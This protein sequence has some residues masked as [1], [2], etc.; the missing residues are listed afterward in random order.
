[1][2]RAST[3][4]GFDAVHM[5]KQQDPIV[6]YGQPLSAHLH[7]GTGRTDFSSTTNSNLPINPAHI[8]D[9]GYQPLG[10]NCPFY[11]EWALYIWPAPKLNGVTT[12]SDATTVTQQAPTGTHVDPAPYG[13]LSIVGNANAG[14][15]QANIRFTCGDGTAAQWS[16]LDGPGSPSPVDCTGVPGGVVTAEAKNPDCYDG[17]GAVRN[18]TTG[19]ITFD[20]PAGISLSHFSYSVNGQCAAGSTL[21]AQIVTQQTFIDNRTTI[22]GVANPDYNKQLRNPLNPDGSVALSFASGAYQTY[23]TDL[24]VSTGNSWRISIVNQC[25]NTTIVNACPT[26]TY[27]GTHVAS[28]QLA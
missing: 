25:L 23:H 19:V 22:N 4:C 12:L 21:I 5:R 20:A 9:P 7:D 14:T 3:K 24:I 11:A 16:G 18:P 15:P 17:Q 10:S 13:M 8:D 27:I 28:H 1:M 6:A 26:G 2:N